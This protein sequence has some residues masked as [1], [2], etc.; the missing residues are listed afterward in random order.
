MIALVLAASQ[1]MAQSVLSIGVKKGKLA[2][3]VSR[4]NDFGK[5]IETDEK[6]SIF[7]MSLTTDEAAELASIR[8]DKSVLFVRKGTALSHLDDTNLNSLSAVN[9]TIAE[10]KGRNSDREKMAK[11]LGLPPLERMDKIK[12]G[13]YEAYRYWLEERAYPNNRVNY[14][15]YEEGVV[16]RDQM[17][18]AYGRLGDSLGTM[19]WQFV[20]PTNLDIPYS[21]YYGVRPI[22][23]RV[24]ALAVDPTNPN[25]LYLGGGWGGV[26]KST[27]G[28]IDWTALTDGWEWLTVSSI[29]VHPT[30]GNIIYVGT[31]DY[32]GGIGYQFGIMKSLDGGATWTNLGR[33]EFGTRAVSSIAIDPENPNIVTVSTGRGSGGSG[34]VW[35]STNGGTSWTNVLNSAFNWSQVSIGALNTTNGVRAYYVSGGGTGGN[36]WRSL[37]RGATWTKLTTLASAATNHSV[38]SVC[39]SPV[40]PDT[41][42]MVVNADRQV[43][44]SVNQGVTWTN[45]TGTFPNGTS[46]YFWSQGTYNWYLN[47]SSRPG[48]QDVIYVGMI[49]AAQSYDGGATWRSI[50]G[51]T[52]VAGALTHN[53]QHFCIPDPT[54]PNRVYIGG[55]GGA[56][57]YTFD[58]ATNNGGWTYLNRNLGVSM[59]YKADFHNSNANVMIGGTQ[60][61]ATPAS[62]GDLANW[63]NC[64]GGDG[65]FSCINQSSPNIQYTTSQSLGV[66]RTSNY[67]S[68]QTTIT[69]STGGD[70]KAFIA[71]IVLDPNNYN[72]LYA[73]TNYL[74]R[75]DDAT[76]VWT[77]RLGGQ[78]LS[79]SG[80]LRAITIAPGDTN[81]IYTGASDG[82]VWMSTDKGVTWTQIN[83]GLTSLPNRTIT[84]ISANPANKNEILVT[85]S[86]T[87]SGHV[88]K[89]P[90]TLAG[91][92]RTWTDVSGSGITGLPNV[93]AQSICSDIFD[94]DRT[95]FVGTD[96]G[97]F[98][99]ENG[100]A[101]W[102]SATRP[103]GL[104]NVR[105][106][107]VKIAPGLQTLYA[108]TY[109]RG[110]WKFDLPKTYSPVTMNVLG[111]LLFGGTVADL[112]SSD[113]LS[114][115]ILNDEFDANG[116]IELTYAATPG[117]VLELYIAVETGASRTDLTQIVRLYDQVAGTWVN[118]D[119]WAS[120]ISDSRIIVNV[121][122]NP[123]RFV[124]ASGQ[125]KAR[126]LWV[127][128]ADTS[129][130]DGWTERVDRIVVRIVR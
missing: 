54:N 105:A 97:V 2:S 36:V 15:A 83:I 4:L 5:L 121:T 77:A 80:N 37:D 126:L 51:P 128:T 75:R 13:Y 90:N 44:K 119:A 19:Q 127:P 57:R 70:S 59:F 82:Q 114:V 8:K 107:D 78:L 7:R 115:I 102:T 100:G 29:A 20:G 58:P 23:G 68:S 65:G 63:E 26:W 27:N 39:A 47:V 41:V 52:Y 84:H 21:T 50:G 45:I 9:K 18:P 17:P 66:Y 42:Y 89:C 125:I 40:F 32:S 86:G 55:D 118:V 30:N 3:T 93:P 108:A 11:I 88:W 120:T 109:G 33:P 122:N 87:G 43:H 56:Y 79:A 106:N 31:G 16:Q 123:S 112:A 72:L 74:W 12:T 64:G 104:P 14:K 46:N 110:M 38:I 49:D 92:A 67:W 94:F 73:G 10:M 101:S 69:P 53:D 96:L 25:T 91:A 61:N 117:P 60:D 113:N 35:R 116:D 48:P 99:T 62:V 95:W 71:P 6:Y 1:L 24:N 124:S 22:N 98:M 28:G 130:V 34:F 129:A 76:G 111:G 103:L 81:R 85:V